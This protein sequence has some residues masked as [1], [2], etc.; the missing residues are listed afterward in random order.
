MIRFLQKPAII[1]P[2]QNLL[3]PAKLAHLLMIIIMISCK[4]SVILK[5]KSMS[6]ALSIKKCHNLV[7]VDSNPYI[8]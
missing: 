3:D 1:D 6:H 7:G 2:A 5:N 8:F 4:K